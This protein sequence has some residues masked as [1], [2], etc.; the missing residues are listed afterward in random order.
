M[1][2]SLA[3]PRYWPTWLG[4][5]CAWLIAHAPRIVQIG[6]GRVVGAGLFRFARSRRHIAET[7]LQ[8]CFPDLSEEARADLVRAV[9][10]SVGQ[11]AIET[12]IAWFRSPAHYA[13]RLD[14]TG[15]PH[16]LSAQN[17]GRGVVLIGAHFATLDFA[18]ALLSLVADIDVIY[19]YNKN[20]VIEWIMR[21]GRTRLFGGVIE[22]KDTRTVVKRLREGRTVWYA[23]DQDYGRKVSVFAPFF[24]VPAATI[25]AGAR[26]ARL[27]GS[28]AL[29]FSHF[30]DMATGRWSIHFSQPIQGYPSGDDVA[31][32]TRINRLIETEILKHPDQYLWLHRRFKTRPA[33]E[34]RPY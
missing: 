7:N 33:G 24:G 29:F 22:R 14:V 17:Q 30:R 2:I 34:V 9:F 10:R 3:A 4:V 28:P 8:L 20:P 16:L 15:L 32:A 18:G 21:R 27:N 1:G 12:A 11:S 31:D 26:L 13:D 5:C 6:L 25:T 23:A 19:R